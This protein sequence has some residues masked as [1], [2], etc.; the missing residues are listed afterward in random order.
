MFNKEIIS[1]YKNITPPS[2]LRERIVALD[3][4]QTKKRSFN[5]QAISRIAACLALV[6]VCATA[7]LNLDLS[8][9]A[10]YSSNA[11]IGTKAVAASTSSISYVDSIGIQFFSDEP[12][13][14]QVSGEEVLA[15]VCVPLEIKIAK[16]KIISVSGGDIIM[17]L[18]DDK[19]YINCGSEVFIEDDA[20]IYVAMPILDNGETV[21]VCIGDNNEKSIINITYSNGEYF[22]KEEK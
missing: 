6:L 22:L 9:N 12:R 20:K 10:V 16:A 17:Y 19:A 13:Q 21:T 11:R 3:K 1:E 7:A 2:E 18:A 15:P 8:Q 14:R 4:V 5:M